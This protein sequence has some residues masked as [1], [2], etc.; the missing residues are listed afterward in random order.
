MTKPIP[1]SLEAMAA[2]LARMEPV[3]MAL[4][5]AMGVGPKSAV[6]SVLPGN[7]EPVEAPKRRRSGKRKRATVK[8]APPVVTDAATPVAPVASPERDRIAAALAANGGNVSRTAKAMKV[9][10]ATMYKWLA[11]HGLKTKKA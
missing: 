9:T 10:R 2:C 5:T 3:L 11:K 8:A 1:E 4:A 6:K 7:G